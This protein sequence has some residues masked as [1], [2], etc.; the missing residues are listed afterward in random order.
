MYWAETGAPGGVRHDPES[1]RWCLCIYEAPIP[2]PTGGA[3][4]L[5]P[6]RRPTAE[7]APAEAK[8]GCLYPNNARALIEAHGRGFDNC[9]LRDML[10]NIAELGTANVF[11][12]KDGA[13]YTPAANGTF[14]N[15]ITRQRII[16]LL[17]ENGVTVVEAVMTYADFQNADEIFSSGNYSK[18]SPFTRIDDRE[19]QPGPFYGKARELYWAFAHG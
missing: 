7:C 16:T 12:A 11:T 13:V 6:F 3:I 19:L 8:A 1:T 9:L 14:L 17:R 15:G 18:V 5:S 2:K 4:T 10:G